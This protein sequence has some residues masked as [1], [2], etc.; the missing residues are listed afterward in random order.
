MNIRLQ[1]PWWLFKTIRLLLLS[2]FFFYVCLHLHILRWAP[3]HV[4]SG[5]DRPV[6]DMTL[7]SAH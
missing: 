5:S 4:L 2:L 7:P 1:H 3:N 6:R